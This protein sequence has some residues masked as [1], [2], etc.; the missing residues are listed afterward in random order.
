MESQ[1]GGSGVRVCSIFVSY[2][3]EDAE[4]QAGRLFDDLVAHFGKDSVFMDVVDIELGRDFRRVIDQQIASCGFLLAVIGKGWLN[5]TDNEGRRRL[6]DSNDF[7]RLEIAAAL[8]RNIRVIPVLVQGAKMPGGDSLPEDLKELAFRNAVELTHARWDSDTQ[9]LIKALDR[10]IQAENQQKE[11]EYTG[12]IAP[13]RSDETDSKRSG[14]TPVVPRRRIPHLTTLIILALA[15]G[16]IVGGSLIYVKIQDAAEEQR[17]AAERLAA[18]RAQA[19]KEAEAQKAAAEKLAAEKAQAEKLA[20]ERAQARKEAEAQKAAAEKFAAEKAQAEKI[21]QQRAEQERNLQEQKAKE[22]AATQIVTLK[23]SNFFPTSHAN[24]VI[25]DQWCKEVEKRTKGRVKF[26]YFPAGTLTSADK[27]YDSVVR[28]IADVGASI[29]AYSRGRFP[30]F[31]VVDLPLAYKSGLAASR[32]ANELYKKYRPKELAETQVMYLH[33]HGPGIMHSKKSVNKLEDVKGMKIKSTGVSA[34]IVQALGGLPVALPMAEAYEALSR[35]VVDGI[36]SPNDALK[37]WKLSEVTAY[38]TESFGCA[39]S[40]CH[41]VVMNKAKWNSLPKDVQAVIEKINEEW[42]DKQGKLWDS[43][44]I[45]GR[46]FATKQGMRFISLSPDE[47][48]RWSKAVRPILDD[49]VRE[50]K[51]KGQPG[52]GALKFCLDYLRTHDR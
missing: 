3:R 42:I 22:A 46:Q 19:R 33:A 41:V 37:E 49:Y 34:K 20:A 47:D 25:A 29:M 5:T 39:Y 18:E 2:R 48:A 51:A 4:G 21:A 26:N 23:Y 50:A 24:S 52:D 36:L 45:E 15:V 7:V 10:C 44:G 9:V 31:D 1:P 35:G 13:P 17:I 14:P 28:G 11:G 38:T 8:K 6:D 16:I 30:L 32:M 43:I 40:T 27:T 12:P